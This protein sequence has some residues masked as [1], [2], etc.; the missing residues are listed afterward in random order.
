MRWSC[1]SERSRRSECTTPFRRW[2]PV[3]RR[4]GAR[5]T[6]A[7]FCSI[8][9][10]SEAAPQVARVV[11]GNGY[12][13]SFGAG[14]V[15]GVATPYIYPDNLPRTNARGGP[16]GKPGCWAPITRDLWPAPY[17]VFDTGASVAPYNHF[18]LGQPLFVDYVWGRQLG[19]Y[20]INP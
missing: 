11:G 16:V 7:S 6:R 13:I 5:S 12:S 17:L 9:Q 1:G 18:G 3:S 4:P 8:R 19:E 20:T 2:P 10:Y 15:G 14:T